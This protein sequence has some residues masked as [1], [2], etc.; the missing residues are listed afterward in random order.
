MSFKKW[1]CFFVVLGSFFLWTGLTPVWAGEA[2][3]INLLKKKNILT[4]EEADELQK[5]LRS[6][7]QQEKTEIKKEVKAE[8]K[9]DIKKD[10]NQ[11]DFLPKALKGFKFGAQIFGEWN[12]KSF[13]NGKS[14][15]TFTLNR[16]QFSLAKD[17]N[18]W[19]GMN[20]TADFFNAKDVNDVGNGY[21]LRLKYVYASMK[22]FGT[23]TLI[24]LVPYTSDTYD[25]S[26][27]PYRVQGKNLLDDLGIQST[28]DLGIVNQGV[29][30]GYM[31]DDY[32]KYASKPFAGKWGGY[33]IGIYNGSGYTNVY[34]STNSA[35]SNNNKAVSGLVYF[36]PFPTMSILQ[37]LQLAYTGTYGESG[38][39]YAAGKGPA[40]QYPKWQVNVGQI[41][42]QHPDFTIMGQYYWG[43]GAY[44]FSTAN[45]GEENDRTA[46]LVSA[47]VRI[48]GVKKLRV[49]GKM[50]TYDPDTN[51]SNNQYTIY[52]A[53]LSY[54]VTPEFM[55]FVAYEHKDAQPTQTD[56][57]YDKFQVGFQL[58]F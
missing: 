3:L 23:E 13:Q 27:W 19:L 43:K 54:D 25:N 29:F 31:D 51:V 18:D 32:L 55:P 56:I 33:M 38:T 48:P 36:R 53:G 16:G 9:E 46:Y 14:T 12:S 15:N 30:G 37:G 57:N 20:I 4:Q 58:K 42:L 7:S 17:I 26:I 50:Y 10:A 24:G 22:F 41:S 8:I 11:G 2:E 52:V 28:Y 44:Y 1:I 47:F 6:T 40:G 21:E 45:S 34:A 35:D 39:A 49:F 5:E